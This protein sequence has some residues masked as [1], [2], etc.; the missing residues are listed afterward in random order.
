MASFRSDGRWREQSGM[1]VGK[2]LHVLG[3]SELCWCPASETR[4]DTSSARPVQ[5]LTL[6]RP[7]SSLSFA[8]S[9][10]SA[11]QNCHVWAEKETNLFGSSLVL[12]CEFGR[13]AR[14]CPA[15]L[16]IAENRCRN[17]IE[18]VFSLLTG[19]KNSCLPIDPCTLQWCRWVARR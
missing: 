3:V 18:K 14:M 7:D 10:T 16:R 9:S 13:I 11:A 5:A 2:R 17:L 6:S 4:C 8:P 12:S 19:L 1:T 15:N